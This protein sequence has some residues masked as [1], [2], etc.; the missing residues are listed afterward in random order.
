MCPATCALLSGRH[1]AHDS[2]ATL[3]PSGLAA[4]QSPCPRPT[5]SSARAVRARAS[6][7]GHTCAVRACAGAAPRLARPDSPGDR[8]PAA[9]PYPWRARP[10]V[11]AGSAAPLQLFQHTGIYSVP[12]S[13]S[14]FRAPH[15]SSGPD[16]PSRRPPLPCSFPLLL[17]S[18][19]PPPA[20]RRHPHTPLLAAPPST[21]QHP[22][23]APHSAARSVGI[24]WVQR[25]AAS[26]SSLPA[27]GPCFGFVRASFDR[28]AQRGGIYVRV[29]GYHQ[30]R[31]DYV[32]PFDS[33]W[34]LPPSAMLHVQRSAIQMLS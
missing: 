29:T 31:H 16:R 18:C 13:M 2:R 26:T 20:G 7:A 24:V 1:G 23:L 28:S 30:M 4:L 27:C 19:L 25:A 9:C 21:P 8:R 10:R 32:K 15:P 34:S 12:L 17:R 14:Q 5:A 33:A 22:G 11:C 6:V 3:P